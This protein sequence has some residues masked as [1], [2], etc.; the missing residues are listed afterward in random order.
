MNN[1]VV[2]IPSL[3]PGAAQ[4]IPGKTLETL[5]GAGTLSGS[6]Y[7]RLVFTSTSTI[8]VQ[9]LLVNPSGSISDLSAT[10]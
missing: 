3:A 7:P 5:I 8:E 10:Q 1:A 9:S 4:N 2:V 6:S